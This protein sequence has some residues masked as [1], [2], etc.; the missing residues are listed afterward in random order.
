VRGQN[1]LGGEDEEGGDEFGRSSD[2]PDNLLAM[3]FAGG[4]I[5]P[6]D[7]ASATWLPTSEESQSH[8]GRH[9]CVASHRRSLSP[10]NRG[11]LTDSSVVEQGIHGGFQTGRH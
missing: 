8:V 7:T 10:S 4:A 1:D 3:L 2:V 5:G 9:L 6:L 11:E